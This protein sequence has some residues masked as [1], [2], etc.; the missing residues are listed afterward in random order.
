MKKQ[1]I[2]VIAL[3]ALVLGA[4]SGGDESSEPE[5]GSA[6]LPQC[7]SN[8]YVSFDSGN[9][10]NQEVRLQTHAS[11]G[12]L[13][14]EAAALHADGNTSGAAQ[15]FSEAKAL[16]TDPV[17]SAKLQEKV[18]GR[19]DE[20][21]AGA[22]SQGDRL[23]GTIIAWLDKGAAATNELEATIARQW[24][25]K[26]L[27]EFFFLSVHHEILAGTKKNWDEGFGYYGSGVDNAE[28]NLLGLAQTAHKRDATNGTNMEAEIY[29]GLID[30]SCELGTELQAS[31]A[32]ALE[33]SSVP[34]LKALVDDI[35][36]NMQLVLAYSAG[37]EAFE[38]AEVL[39]ASPRD[40]AELFIKAAE[41]IPFFLPLERIMLERGGE[42]AERAKQ[43]RGYLD[44]MPVSDPATLDVTDTTWI[45]ALGDAPQNIINA[46]E[47]E[48]GIDIKG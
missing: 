5:T 8:T 7:S 45:D 46:L 18:Q 2:T 23:D 22:P 48:Y 6:T 33:L 17:A 14:K 30:G 4:C 32:D 21:L 40:D 28:S 37:H 42:S 35:D 26:T 13:M 36:M 3:S 44:A 34:A 43:I 9:H 24:V 15:K 1:A 25:D 27:T 11:L 12:S 10:A 41:L 19:L 31:G 47:A 38:M 39:E 16:Y 20:H 29:N